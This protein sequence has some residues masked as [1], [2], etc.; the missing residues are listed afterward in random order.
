MVFYFQQKKG[1]QDLGS[2]SAQRQKT[3]P[4][5][6]PDYAIDGELEAILQ[7][8]SNNK[9]TTTTQT[10]VETI[11]N[12]TQTETPY[13]SH[14]DLLRLIL[15]K[16]TE[17]ETKMTAMQTQLS[18]ARPTSQVTADLVSSALSTL[19]DDPFDFEASETTV[20][21]PLSV[22][23]PTSRHAYPS[24][25][26]SRPMV[27]TPRRQP[28]VNVCELGFWKL[29]PSE[30]LSNDPN[31]VLETAKSKLP[32]DQIP[33]EVSTVKVEELKANCLNQRA[34][35]AKNLVHH[36]IT[37]GELYNRNVN[38]R[39][40]TGVSKQ[41]INP[42]KMNY[43]KEVTYKVFPCLP[44]EVKSSWSEC[45]KVIDKSNVYLFNVID[46]KFD[47]SEILDYL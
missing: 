16:V 8:A 34:Q 22:T 27:S 15:N 41:K 33:H 9:R 2:G 40:S 12:S 47:I 5:N 14:D 31:S 37:V 43:V 11:T 30:I 4:D 39:N 35:F 32:T 38:G 18:Q 20:L 29:L 45:V 21:Q 3:L 28:R 24:T 42:T 6:I 17:L 1:A 44:S 36:S 46:K 19:Q 7:D 10:D 26:T 25:P 13:E 23:T